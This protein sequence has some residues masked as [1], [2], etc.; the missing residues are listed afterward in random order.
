MIDFIVMETLSS[1]RNRIGTQD[2]RSCIGKSILVL[3]STS[4]DLQQY[5]SLDDTSRHTKVDIIA[6]GASMSPQRQGK[7]MDKKV[8]LQYVPLVFLSERLRA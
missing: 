1:Q 3:V 8:K 7:P 6:V 2:S 4:N 5:I